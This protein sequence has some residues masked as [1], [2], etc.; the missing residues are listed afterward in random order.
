MPIGSLGALSSGGGSAISQIGDV[1]KT[2]F[3]AIQAIKGNNDLKALNANRPQRETDP[4]YFQNQQLA[5]QGASQGLSNQE[6]N[7][8][9]TEIGQNTAAGI[10]AVEKTGGSA[11]LISRLV[12][13]NNNPFLKELALDAQQKRTNMQDLYGANKD[14][15]NQNNINWDYNVNVPFQQKYNQAVN[16]TNAGEQNFF[17][18]TQQLGSNMAA[19]STNNYSGLQGAL[20]SKNGLPSNDW[21]GATQGLTPEVYGG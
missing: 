15:A 2:V 18:G 11:N 1:G 3:G 6:R 4:L 21:L 17:T 9:D 8:F 14:L 20:A 10:N 13:Q 7:A 19:S 5:E 16:Q 12:N